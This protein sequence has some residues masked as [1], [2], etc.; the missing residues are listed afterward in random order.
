MKYFYCHISSVHQELLNFDFQMK[1][2]VSNLFRRLSIHKTGKFTF[3]WHTGS[4]SSGKYSNV[5]IEKNVRL[6]Y[7]KKAYTF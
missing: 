1:N 7:M 2:K 6:Q 3:K 5:K 4:H